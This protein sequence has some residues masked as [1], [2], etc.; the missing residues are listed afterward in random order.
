MSRL[1]EGP[2]Q[3]AV[4]HRLDDGGLSIIEM[5]RRRGKTKAR[6]T[7]AAD[8][9]F[10]SPVLAQRRPA[11]VLHGTR[12]FHSDLLSGPSGSGDFGTRPGTGIGDTSLRDGVFSTGAQVARSSVAVGRNRPAQTRGPVLRTAESWSVRPGGGLLRQGTESTR[13]V[14]GK[15]GSDFGSTTISNSALHRKTTTK[16]VVDMVALVHELYGMSRS[17]PT[18]DDTAPEAFRGEWNPGSRSDLDASSADAGMAT[19]LELARLVSTLD[20]R[21]NEITYDIPKV[22]IGQGGFGRVWRSAV[23]GYRG[24]TVAVKEL[25]VKRDSQQVAEQLDA[26]QLEIATL[27]PLRHPGLTRVLG[28]CLRPPECFFVMELATAGSLYDAVLGPSA[29]ASR[30]SLYTRLRIL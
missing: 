17:R 20:C 25:Y 23:G 29:P 24:N 18:Q 19:Q 10:S 9:V 7:A 21:P 16:P 4:W 11:R 6:S 30:W 2:A 26:M 3:L 14:G 27:L 13:M 1:G 22:L 5:L 12:S 28:Y 15:P 8:T